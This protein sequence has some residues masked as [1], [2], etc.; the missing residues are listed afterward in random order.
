M[1]TW[2]RLISGL[3]ALALL[4]SLSCAALA[5]EPKAE[6]TAAAK[7]AGQ[8]SQWFP[9]FEQDPAAP[10]AVEAVLAKMGTA[11]KQSK[12]VGG[13]TATLNGAVWDGD[14]LRLSLAVKAPGIPKEVAEKTN[15]YTEE[16]SLTLP[17]ET[18]KEY[19]RKDEEARSEKLSKELL[20]QSIQTRLEEGQVSY[21]R[22]HG[23]LDFYLLSREGNTLTFE[24]GM[25]LRDYLKQPELTLHLENIA[26]YEDGKGEV[27]WRGDQRTGP[28][29]KDTILK[30]PMDFTFK[31]GNVLPAMKYTGDVK[32]TAEGVPFRF[33][34][35]EVGPFEMNVDYE[36]VTSV[37]SIHVTRPGEPEPA[38]DPDKLDHQDVSK[39]LHKV[40]QGLWTKDGKYVDLSQRGGGSSMITSPEGTC[41]GNVGGGYP[42]PID[43]ATVTAVKLGETRVE[44]A[45]LKIVTEQTAGE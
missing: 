43:P 25:S 14:T 42:H 18:W 6:K 44:L 38:A 40:V 29:P 35:F 16:C 32:V 13:V 7:S 33:T 5:A 1:K 3:L 37:N 22:F 45:K 17:E 41:G 31:L 27:T 24:A 8:F 36:V 26:T 39:A 12:T 2:K 15:L 20:E 23:M 9:R 21:W 11:I 4:A 19:V 28:G 10:E 34:G 30:G